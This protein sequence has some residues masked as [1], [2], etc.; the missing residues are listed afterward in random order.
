MKRDLV[1][2]VQQFH[3]NSK[4]PRG[5]NSSF[6]SL[7]PK[8]DTPQSL[9]EYRP[10]S[11]IGCMYKI[12]A[13]ILA[14]RLK[15]VLPY[16]VDHR[17]MGFVEGRGLLQGAM[18]LNETLD[19]VRRRKKQGD[20][21]APFLFVLVAEGLTGLVRE[22]SNSDLFRGIKVGSKGELVNILQYADD[23]IFVGEASVENVRTL[24]VILRGFE[25]ASGLKV[26]FYKSC[27]GA[28]GVGRETLISFAE[29]LHCKLSNIPFVYLGIPIGANPRRSKTWQPVV[30]SFKKKLSS[31]RAS[32]LSMAGR[33]CLINS[34]LTS[35]PLYIM[36]FYRMP[37]MVT[38]Q[39]T[40]IQRNFLW[41]GKL[42]E[43]RMAWVSWEKICRPKKEGGLGIKKLDTFN[44]A[45]LAKWRWGLFQQPESMWARIL[46]SKY[47]DTIMHNT[48]LR[49]SSDSMWW[50]DV[51][52][53]SGEDTSDSWFMDSLSWR[54]GMGDRIRFWSDAWAEAEP[55]A[56]RFP[57]I[58]SNSLQKSNVVANMGHWSRGRWQWRFQWR[59]AWFTWELNDVQQFM[60]IVEARVLIEGVQD[61]RLWTL[62]SS[63]C[64][65]VRSGYRALM[66]R[67]P[68]SQLP[69]VAAVAWDIK[70]PPKVKCFIWRLFMGALPTKENLLRRNVI[71]LRDQATCPFCNADIESSEHILLY[72]SSTDPIWKKWLLW[73]DSPTPLSS[74]FEGNFFAHPSILLSKKRV[75]QWH[76]IWTA[77]L[78]CIWRARNKY[79]FEGEHLDGNRLLQQTVLYSWS[80][81]T[82]FDKS[83]NYSFSQWEANPGLCIIS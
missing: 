19:E 22:A 27:L 71:V 62:D 68:S 6:I 82:S 79:V 21:L 57:R 5:T 75:D 35:L 63:G 81:L 29:I 39:L 80:W 28:I 36:S 70:V 17:Q 31:W 65:S 64:F 12:L 34:V 48:R 30:L 18:V 14:L 15:V 54:L 37:K 66:D 78:W 45:L 33:I 69:N 20:P 49:G 8:V 4:L 23:T 9:N 42:D 41:G 58:F 53:A 67:G 51:L 40:S 7:I 11:L 2:F 72:C 1:L 56:N 24:K 46:L 3:D 44:A 10:I 77:I 13:K 50:G 16:L 26:N 32:T 38:K 74:S 55:L 60:N 43:K 73:L 25:L 61:S 47:G 59:R 76:V 83:F 52:K